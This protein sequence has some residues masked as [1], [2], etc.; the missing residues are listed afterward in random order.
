MGHRGPFPVRHRLL[1]PVRVAA[2]LFL[3]L[4]AS[5]AVS[6]EPRG[7]PVGA[8]RGTPNPGPAPAGGPSHPTA[9]L[10]PRG[11]TGEVSWPT[12]M[13]S[14]EHTGA[15]LLE[16]TI[17]PSNVSALRPVW[18]IPTNGSDLSAP[19]VAN[20]TVYWGAW[21]G[22]EYAASAS[23]GA[24]EWSRFL[25]YD[26]DCY[27]HG[28]EST[29]ALS[30][31][32]LYL[33]APNG[34][35]DALNASTGHLDWSLALGGPT[36][37]GYYDW[38]SA[39]VFHHELYVGEASCADNPLVAGELLQVNLS[40][41]PSVNHT[42]VAPPPGRLGS[43]IWTTPTADPG[44]DTIWV[45][46]GNDEGSPQPYAQSV[47]GLNAS[48]LA[49]R[50]SWEVPNVIGTD[51]D[52][53]ST[54]TL[55]NPASGSPLV[56][57]SNKNGVLYAFNRSNV[58]SPGW[59]PVWRDVTGGGW[60]GAA[61]DGTTVFAAGGNSVNY[62]GTVE[63]IDPS[64]GTVR[65]NTSVGGGYP[66]ASL[67]YANGLVFTGGGGRESAL[68]AETGQVLWNSTAPGADV[69]DGESVVVDGRLFVASGAPNGTSGHLT[70][71]G[72]PFSASASVAAPNASVPYGAAFEA[73]ATGGMPPYSYAWTFD[74][75]TN[76]T[77][78][79]V[80]H[81]FAHAGSHWG[82]V[83]V[84]DAAGDRQAF[85]L[86]VTT[87]VPAP[88]LEVNATWARVGGACAPGTTT[89]Q[90]RAEPSG[91]ADSDSIEW[92]FGDGSP[93]ATGEP[94]Q[95]AYGRAGQYVVNVTASDPDGASGTE[96]LAVALSAGP[97]APA[98]SGPPPVVPVLGALAIASAVLLVSSLGAMGALPGPW[99]R[100]ASHPA[101]SATL[102]GP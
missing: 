82:N 39:L 81:L 96:Q 87:T 56:L 43:T 16:R 34:S 86:P 29:P 60:S 101:T 64:D 8:V 15:N 92:Q 6:A 47:V 55:V 7:G 19:I 49:L 31:G 62:S 72:L 5:G 40:G 63:A 51:S 85:H 69:I 83:T 54:A 68:D 4:S 24:L 78:P 100:R 48:T 14:P 102:P 89:V 98:S 58:T 30:N 42:W 99:R 12:F 88:N 73:A 70:A 28:L 71:F 25:G 17:A 80:D 45:T 11:G 84:G 91:N 18:S 32:T 9:A 77:G 35:W 67:T 66:W 46:T 13:G 76:Q 53:G 36:S 44:S 38:A 26:S 57:A 95:H 37:R 59:G 20:G 2:V 97:C 22:Y 1:G 61:F 41:P 65:W 93:P 74:D 75:G 79:A 50:G 10:V 27:V 21:N 33:G 3:L 23:T 90:F 94:V 52:F